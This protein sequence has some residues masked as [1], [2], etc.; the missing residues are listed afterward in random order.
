MPIL[1]NLEFCRVHL[2][3]ILG[4][5]KAEVFYG[6]DRKVTLVRSSKEAAFLE[7]LEHLMDMLFVLC[8]V[9]GV[10]KDVVEIDD[11]VNI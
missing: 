5:D 6:V 9:V 3:T 7:A 2:E 11:D 4:K 8:L 1:D 10:N